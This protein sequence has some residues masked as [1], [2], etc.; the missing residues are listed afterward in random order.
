MAN[1]YYEKD[2]DLKYLKGRKVAVIGYGSQG[3]AQALNLK[4]SGI[5]VVVGLRRNSTSKQRAESEGLKTMTVEEA[6]KWADVVQ[7]LIWDEVQG[8]VYREE[9]E[10]HL[11]PG[12][13]LMFSH[14]FNIHYGQIKPPD[15]VDVILIAPK[16]PGLRLREMY[17]EGMGVP[18]LLA[19]EQDYS[20]DA[21]NIA[22][23]YAKAIGSARAGV[24]ETTFGE[25]TETDLFGEQTILCGGVSSLIK[26]AFNTLVEAGYQPEV[27]YFE[28]CHELKLI[29]DLI[30]EGGLTKMRND[31][32]DTA[33]Y[34]DYRSGDRVINDTSREEM[35]KILDAIQDGTFAKE[36]ML[37]NQVGR[38]YFNARKKKEQNSLLERVGREVR[39]MIPWIDGKEEPS[40]EV[41][42]KV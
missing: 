21:K 3:R 15:F 30:N 16:S 8:K 33:E 7:I 37:E 27:A 40:I 34:G 32:S 1:M 11:E 39:S 24:L 10:E 29:V 36:W 23:A 19:V 20:G 9:I 17:E 5:D 18:C 26:S 12:N 42:K 28:C 25:E 31:C 38:P 14:G 4:D 13:V 6:A 41:K 22:L 35:K 2:A